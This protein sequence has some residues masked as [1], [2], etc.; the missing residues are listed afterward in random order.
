MNEG[1]PRIPVT[2]VGWRLKTYLTDPDEYLA[3]TRKLLHLVVPCVAAHFP[4]STLARTVPNARQ[5]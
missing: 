5:S 4:L 1:F 3:M 2:P